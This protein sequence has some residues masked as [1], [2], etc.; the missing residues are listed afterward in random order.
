MAAHAQQMAQ[1]QQSM[2]ALAILNEALPGRLGPLLRQ[3]P[4]RGADAGIAPS[5]GEAAMRGAGCAPGM[6]NALL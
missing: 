3:V 5:P 4:G 1:H 2:A 6:R